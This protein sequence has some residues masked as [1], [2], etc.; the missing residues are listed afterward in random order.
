MA[1]LV[2]RVVT[3][4]VARVVTRLVTRLLVHFRERNGC[5]A[6]AKEELNNIEK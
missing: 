6:E 5:K 3:R 2:A 4:L 1:R